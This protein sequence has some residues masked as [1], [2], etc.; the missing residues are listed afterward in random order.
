[1]MA[2]SFVEVDRSDGR[3]QKVYLSPDESRCSQ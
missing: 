3:Q 2:C 1:L